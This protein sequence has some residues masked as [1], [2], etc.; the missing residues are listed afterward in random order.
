MTAE[1][2]RRRQWRSAWRANMKAIVNDASRLPQPFV[3][4]CRKR[5]VAK[6]D[7]LGFVVRKCTQCSAGKS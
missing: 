7:S 3:R 2:F 1:P 4:R 5:T 6:V